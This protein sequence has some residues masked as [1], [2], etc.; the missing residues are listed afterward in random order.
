M[1]TTI[2]H[3]GM[4]ALTFH[5]EDE[6]FAVQAE[7]VREILDPVPI[8]RVPNAAAFVGGLINV[9]GTV[10]PLADLR[11]VFGMER[12]PPDK[13]TRIIVVEFTLDDEPMVTGILAD[14]VHEVTEIEAASMEQV[15]SVGMRWPPAFI[16][17]IGKRDDGFVVIP[18]M[19]RIFRTQSGR[20]AAAA[21]LTEERHEQ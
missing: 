13:D 20:D 5:L 10:V 1:S 16:R 2:E 12:R 21:N 6:I 18:D 9:R 7:S 14:R 17:S 11:V 8:T 3:H 4:N 15:P 19:E